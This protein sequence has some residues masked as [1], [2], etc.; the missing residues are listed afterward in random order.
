MMRQWRLLYDNPTTG[1]RNMALDEAVLRSVAAGDTPPT[2]RVSDWNPPCLSLG[3][4]QKSADVDFMRAAKQGWD[5]IRRPTGG[6]A[7]LHIDELTYSVIVPLDHPLAQGD[8]IA[9][10]QRISTALLAALEILGL[11]PRA[12]RR[13]G[14]H[15]STG[16]VCFEMP[17]HYEVT[18]GGRKLVG[19]A[20]LRRFGGL[21]QHGSIPLYG[22]LGRICDGLAFPDET[23]RDQAK[24]QVHQHAITLAEA[25]PNATITWQT[26]AA[27]IVE[28][29]TKTF[30]IE[31]IKG[32]LSPTESETADQLYTTVYNNQ[33]WIKRR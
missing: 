23:A 13:T 6:R 3:Y 31:F 24:I 21:L 2:L 19:S 22:D 18:A 4:A 15:D 1:A 33:E 20:Q 8:V 10:Y 29:F 9:S 27:A 12:D 16:A 25:L 17:S 11:N 5:V 7:V 32:S 14:R 30:T 26:L 28:G